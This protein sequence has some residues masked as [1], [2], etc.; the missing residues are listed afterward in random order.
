MQSRSPLHGLISFLSRVAFENQSE[1]METFSGVH[2]I[3]P[4]K[5]PVL[6]YD[7]NIEFTPLG[8]VPSSRLELKTRGSKPLVLPLHQDGMI[9]HE[10]IDLNYYEQ[11]WRLSCYQLHQ[12]RINVLSVGRYRTRTCDLG[13]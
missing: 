13:V 2:H 5:R 9:W 7:K 6:R 1:Y 10:L 12:T 3:F 8:L 11:F 4:V